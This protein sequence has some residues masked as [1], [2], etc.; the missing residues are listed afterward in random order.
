MPSA[1]TYG[2]GY[3]CFEGLNFHSHLE[4]DYRYS[5][6]LVLEVYHAYHK[7]E[8]QGNSS[9]LSYVVLITYVRTF[10]TNASKAS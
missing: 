2:G 5:C 6:L 8:H 4:I 7:I 1:I 3:L 10:Y 9:S